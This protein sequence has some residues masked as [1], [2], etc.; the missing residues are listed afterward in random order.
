MTSYTNQYNQSQIRQEKY[1]YMFQNSPKKNTLSSALHLKNYMDYLPNYRY[2][3]II[4][5]NKRNDTCNN[6]DDY[7]GELFVIYK[8]NNLDE[9]YKNLSLHFNIEIKRIYVYINNIIQIVPHGDMSIRKYILSNNI[10]P[11]F[12]DSPVMYKIFID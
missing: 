4:D 7:E 1:N 10:K 11:N 2:L 12:D 6:N 5:K 9:L 8:D 3:F